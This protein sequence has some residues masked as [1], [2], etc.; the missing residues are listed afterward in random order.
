LPA[1]RGSE[2]YQRQQSCN[3]QRKPVAKAGGY[4]TAVFLGNISVES[5]EGCEMPRKHFV[6][7][8]AGKNKLKI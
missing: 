2:D 5:K 6:L 8:W 4:K 1:I 7:C 3:L